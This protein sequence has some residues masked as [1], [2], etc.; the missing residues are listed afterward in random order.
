MGLDSASSSLVFPTTSSYRESPKVNKPLTVYPKL[1][2]IAMANVHPGV[3]ADGGERSELCADDPSLIGFPANV[4]PPIA[5]LQ[6]PNGPAAGHIHGAN[7]NGHANGHFLNPS[8]DVFD[9]SL[10]NMGFQDH[11]KSPWNRVSSSLPINLA[12]IVSNF[13]YFSMFGG[14]K[15][16]NRG[17]RANLRGWN[18]LASWL[19][20]L[21]PDEDA[22]AEQLCFCW[23]KLGPP[24]QPHS[25]E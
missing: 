1:K 19:K 13:D 3:A 17:Q 4:P 22:T 8:A 6:G 9:A 25:G 20:L 21:T 5:G 24:G 15:G 7:G 11:E 2:K 12:K 23:E 14:D 18:C 10:E 16:V